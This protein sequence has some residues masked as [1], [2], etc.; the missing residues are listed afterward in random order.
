MLLA[1]QS[2]LFSLRS[3]SLSLSLWLTRFFFACVTLCALTVTGCASLP[4]VATDPSLPAPSSAM[5]SVQLE[6]AK[7]ILSTGQSKAILQKIA[8]RAPETGIFEKHLA[9]EEAIAGS[10]LVISNK[11]TLFQDGQTTYDAM[12]K[13]IAAARDHINMETYI[14]DDDETGRQFADALIARQR[15]GVQVNLIYDSVGS[16]STPRAF[17]DKLKDAGVKVVEFN[18]VNPLQAKKG[19]ELNQRDHRKLLIVDGQSVFVGGINISG[20]YSSGSAAKRR[21]SQGDAAHVPWRDTHMLI[22]GPVVA[23]FQKMFQE[24]WRKQKGEPL[25]DKKYF[26]QPSVKGKEVI[27]AI[28]SSADEGTTQY[29]STLISAINSAES[30]IY[31]TNAYFVPD[32][33]FLDA[34]K[35]AVARG[36]DVKIILPGRTDSGLVFHAGRSFYTDLLRNGVKIYER[37][38]KLLHAKT[39]LIDGV[40]SSVGSTNLDWRSFLHNDEINAIVLGTD[41]GLQMKAMFD[42][43]LAASEQITLEAWQDRAFML[44]I[45]EGAA[46]VWA[47][48][49]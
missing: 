14:I 5:P 39:A 27:R 15:L 1:N 9:L 10:P 49:L 47:Y 32:E 42:K 48:W 38:E 23:E 3:R 45:K 44:R 30:S 46:R 2:T 17:F 20:V 41:F 4:K 40:W 6:G 18:P 8:A 36:A 43:D 34:L 19:W 22:E 11:V 33:Q 12:F 13:A 16:L 28:G 37:R 35:A 24:T 25:T 31:L 26:P 7:G 21:A 29:Y